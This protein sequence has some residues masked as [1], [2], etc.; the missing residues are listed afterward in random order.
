MLSN[1][2]FLNQ[3]SFK[4]IYKIQTD[5][6]KHLKYPIKT[7][8]QNGILIILFSCIVRGRISLYFS[9]INQNILLGHTRIQGTKKLYSIIDQHSARHFKNN[10]SGP[11][12]FLCSQIITP[13]SHLMPSANQ[14]RVL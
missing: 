3:I 6:Q 11:P 2:Q 14:E 9:P 13:F 4:H 7:L 10:S 1:S 5:P 12:T 8:M